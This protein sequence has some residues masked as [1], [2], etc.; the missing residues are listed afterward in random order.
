VQI[1]DVTVTLLTNLATLFRHATSSTQRHSGQL[2]GTWSSNECLKKER[3]HRHVLQFPPPNY[4]D[5]DAIFLSY[6]DG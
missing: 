3:E 1:Y 4:T 5:L 6:G 2:S